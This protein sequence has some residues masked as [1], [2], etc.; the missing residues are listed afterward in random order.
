MGVL[1]ALLPRFAFAA[2][3]VSG[4][5]ADETWTKANSPYVVVGDVS[6][7]RLT[8]QPGVEVRINGLFTIEVAGGISALGTKDEPIRFAP[9]NSSVWG[10]ILFNYNPLPAELAYCII[11]R[12]YN[13]GIRVLGSSPIIRNC[14]IAN[15]EGVNGGGIFVSNQTSINLVNCSV[16]NNVASATGGGI[17]LST[18]NAVIEG[19]TISANR[20][21]LL[22]GGVRVVP[23]HTSQL[24]IR[25]TRFL[26]NTADGSGGSSFGGGGLH[27][28]GTP[29]NSLQIERSI[30]QGN[31]AVSPVTANG[32]AILWNG[33]VAIQASTFR[34]NFANN[35]AALYIT[36]RPGTLSLRN[37]IVAHN[38]SYAPAGAAF[39]AGSGNSG[40]TNCVI[41]FN[42]GAGLMLSDNGTLINSIIWGNSAS[43]ILA[44]PVT[45][46][47]CD[48]LGGYTGA[49][50]IAV[51]PVFSSLERFSL[52]NA[53]PCVDAGDPRSEFNDA[54]FPP[55]LGTER[56]DMGA[57]G[58][59]GA[60]LW[61]TQPV[62]TLQPSSHR[63]C[64]GCQVTF[65]ADASGS[66]PLSY[67]WQFNG[68]DIPGAVLPTYV[69]SNVSSN[70]VGVYTVV[71]TN[72][73]G[74][75]TSDAAYL[76]IGATELMIDL[77]AG[78]HING[79]VGQTHRIESLSNIGTSNN[80]MFLTNV[81]QTEPDVF[82]VDPTPARQTLRIYR[83]VD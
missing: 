12:S 64:L 54:C 46:S 9:T 43:Q 47:Y 83:A 48:V 58:G 51:N 34:S 56:N 40:I 44:G 32:G 26:N 23:S 73:Y 20:T 81:V 65:L 30:F 35:G 36:G 25:D 22:G 13:S 55:A 7:A 29:T 3:T 67:Q 15:N 76:T 6:V 60:C 75:K 18:P 41:A 71:V 78:L 1:I 59:P 57:Y 21:V 77:Y 5:V 63:T 8:I 52:L 42:I 39:N 45:V 80:W 19:C 50:N 79:V 69:V 62:I 53:S 61:P 70:N 4:A 31:V 66:E 38:H 2:T 24:A 37:S 17:F 74:S 14:T 11:G 49:G 82:W 33:S 72:P 27:G 16:S 10:G 68:G 28:L